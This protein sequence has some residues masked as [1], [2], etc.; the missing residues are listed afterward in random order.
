MKGKTK[1]MEGAVTENEG[2]DVGDAG[3]GV[4]VLHLALWAQ[5]RK[6]KDTE[7]QWKYRAINRR[8][9]GMGH[10]WNIQIKN[11]EFTGIHREY[12]YAGNKQKIYRERTW[13]SQGEY[14]NM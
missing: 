2:G 6:S 11:M 3:G 12:A 13:D 5:S 8:N 7:M 1:G 10:T 14:R 9:I 4:S